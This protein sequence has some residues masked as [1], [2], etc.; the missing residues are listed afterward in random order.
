[1]A[2]D[3][4]T[5]RTGANTTRSGLDAVDVWWRTANYLSV[6]QIY[7]LDNP[8]LERALTPADIKPRLLG[9]WGTTPALNLVYAHLNRLIVE[10]DLDVLYIAGPGHGGPGVVANA[11]IDGTYS[12]LFPDVSFDRDGIRKLFRQ[13]SFPGGIPSHASPETPGSLHE[14]GEL[15][16]SLVH[17]YGAVLDNPGL[18]GAC[19]VGDGEAETATLAASWH[20]NKFLNAESDGAVL[21]I[22][23]LNGYKI[24]N[25]TILARIPEEELLALFRGYGYAPRIVSGGFDNEDPRLVHERLADAMGQAFDDIAAIQ[26]S[27]RGGGEPAR[28]A[29][30]ML[31]LRTPKGWT[32]PKVVDGLPVENT[33]RAHQVPL[34]GVRDNPEH[35]AQL[36][37]WMQSYRPAELFDGSGRPAPGID[38]IRPTLT[39]RMSANPHSNGGELLEPLTVPALEP[40]AIGLDGGRGAIA[41]PTRVLGGWLRELI[42]ANP[43]TFRIFGPDETASNRLDDVYRVTQKAWQGEML[44]TDEHLG[45][46]GRV[47]E[48]L[49]ENLMQGLLEGYLLTGRHGLFTSYEAFI[50]VVDS[51]FNQ[52]AKWLESSAHVEWRRPVASFTYLLSSHVWRQ[53]HN[54]FSHQD[55]GFLNL[56]VNKQASVVRVYLPPDANTLLVTAEHCLRSR[57]YVN[58]IVAGKQ[59]TATLLSLDEARA[60]GARGAGIWDWAGTEVAGEEPDVVVACA[61]DVPT[62]EAMAAVQILKAEV[63]GL[64]VRFINVVDLMRLQDS[65]E[66][67]HGL[68][69]DAFDALFTRDKPVVFAFHGY[70]SLVHQLTYRRTNHQNIHVRGFKERGTTTTPFDMLMMNDLDRFRLVMDVIHRVP[71]LENRYAALSQRMDDER[72]AHRAYTREHGEDSPDVSGSRGLPFRARSADAGTHLDTGDDNVTPASGP[73]GRS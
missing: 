36:Q 31:I 41:E 45:R 27:A 24:A 21:P 50:H 63:P 6:G 40:N 37:E 55:P 25:P 70:P 67:P 35:R 10:R 34:A 38:G 29:W 4:G 23:N 73:A 52:Y 19:V 15:G 5:T 71:H 7:L 42:A 17:A 51:M 8:L 66:H 68:T 46:E 22:L 12:E 33:W 44:P 49:S 20:L 14:G 64:R 65:R 60:H 3:E 9:H 56:V 48:A 13:F 2:Y 16:Y 62:V 69:D 72:I 43:H 39:H 28:P 18:I 11:W 59:P 54:G 58:V 1:M 26:A 30:P 53:D 57:N 47:I 32:G 61:G